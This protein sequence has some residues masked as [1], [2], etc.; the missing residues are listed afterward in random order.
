MV[1]HWNKLLKASLGVPLFQ[2]L[3]Q[4]DKNM[5]DLLEAGLFRARSCTR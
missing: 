1:R 4:L 2:R 5:S 3:I